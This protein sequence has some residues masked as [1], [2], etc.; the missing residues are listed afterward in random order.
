MK[1][2]ALT[3]IALLLAGCQSSHQ[4][5]VVSPDHELRVTSAVRPEVSLSVNDLRA[6]PGILVVRKDGQNQMIPTAQLTNALYQRIKSAMDQAGWQINGSAY[7][8]VTVNILQMSVSVNQ[9]IA[10]YDAQ[11]Q[12]ELRVE[13]SKDG[14]QFAKSFAGNNENHG[15]FSFDQ[16][17]QEREFDALLNSVIDRI[18][19]DP[20]LARFLQ[21]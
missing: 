6:K 16:A 1:K 5:F 11:G 19:A 4:Q 9:G 14:N 20:D 13:A 15:P 18:I 17:V 21:R 3:T 10:S 12:I 7:Q 2:I 8:S